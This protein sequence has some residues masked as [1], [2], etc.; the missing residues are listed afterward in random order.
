MSLSS[1]S[2]FLRGQPSLGSRRRG[3]RQ[4]EKEGKK[5]RKGFHWLG[6]A[7]S[8]DECRVSPFFKAVCSPPRE[9]RSILRR[10]KEKR[11]EERKGLRKPKR[12]RSSLPPLSCPMLSFLSSALETPSPPHHLCLLH[13]LLFVSSSLSF[14]PN[15]FLHSSS[16]S[17]CSSSRTPHEG[18]LSP[19]S[20][21]GGSLSH[22][23][24]AEVS[25]EGRNFPVK[26]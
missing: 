14:Y 18:K 24:E 12:Q 17:C 5:E 4:R 26:T 25:A 13:S 22:T 21:G 9:R 10:K 19:S 16:S 11:K 20:S 3:E 8:S 15:V 6:P 7:S 2:F 1:C 23:A